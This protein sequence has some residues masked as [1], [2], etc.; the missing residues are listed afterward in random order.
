MVL[1]RL[2]AENRTGK[3]RGRGSGV[4]SEATPEKTPDPLPTLFFPMEASP[5]MSNGGP[6]RATAKAWRGRARRAVMPASLTR[7]KALYSCGHTST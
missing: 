5:P 4:V 6:L 2:S 3:K 1:P 7:A